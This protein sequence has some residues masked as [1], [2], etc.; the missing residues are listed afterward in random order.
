MSE[1]KAWREG[2][3]ACNDW[4]EEVLGPELLSVVTNNPS[5]SW[6][7]NP[8]NPYPSNKKETA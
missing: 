5:D 3:E 7:K 4:W 6:P 1:H 8:K 2:F